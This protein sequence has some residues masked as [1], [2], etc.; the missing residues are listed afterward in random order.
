METGSNNTPEI[1]LFGICS[2]KV[3]EVLRKKMNETFF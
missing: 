2:R 1:G 3:T